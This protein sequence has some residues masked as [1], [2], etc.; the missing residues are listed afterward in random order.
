MIFM[1]VDDKIQQAFNFERMRESMFVWGKKRMLIA[2]IL[3]FVF[4][5][6]RPYY[7][8]KFESALK[9]E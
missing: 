8:F 3:S 5:S 7:K 1:T 9:F 4:R 6:K 2:V